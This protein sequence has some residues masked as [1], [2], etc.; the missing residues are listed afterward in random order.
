MIKNVAFI[1]LFKVEGLIL[2]CFR[3]TAIPP[4]VWALHLNDVCLSDQTI[5]GG[6]QDA[7]VSQPQTGPSHLMKLKKD[8]MEISTQAFLCSIL[9]TDKYTFRYIATGMATVQ[10]I[11]YA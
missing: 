7:R 6:T 4:A 11:D 3:N 8:T 5:G 2:R 9:L 10:Y 1:Y